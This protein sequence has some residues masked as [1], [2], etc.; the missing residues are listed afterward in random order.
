MPA[1]L[2]GGGA[3]LA[4][5]AAPGGV[6]VP[7][8]VAAPGGA[9]A[10]VPYALTFPE[11]STHRAFVL[12][13]IVMACA[14]NVNQGD[15]WQL[16]VS[17]CMAFG[18]LGVATFLDPAKPEYKQ[19][20][21]AVFLALTAAFYWYS[22]V[23]HFATALDFIEKLVAMVP[24]LDRMFGG[25]VDMFADLHADNPGMGI[26]KNML[27]HRTITAKIDALAKK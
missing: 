13:F 22:A 27:E 8:G 6:A 24:D 21:L 16:F 1:P 19:Q 2:V 9:A 15:K 14:V 17:P 20:M 26:P 10:P 3:P 7:G 5:V 18:T 12:Y 4:V 11:L 25:C 23:P